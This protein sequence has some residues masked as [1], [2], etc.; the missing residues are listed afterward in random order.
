MT[1]FSYLVAMVYAMVYAVG[2][3]ELG[4]LIPD[5][6]ENLEMCQI[7]VYKFEAVQV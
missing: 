3:T 6:Q 7:G 1:K 2:P 5:V 4:T